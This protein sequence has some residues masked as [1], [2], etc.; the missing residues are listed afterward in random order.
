MILIQ[1]SDHLQ[2]RKWS[3]SRA[4]LLWQKAKRGV[5]KR[6]QKTSS[7]RRFRARALA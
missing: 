7:A 3:L 2:G 5:A 1:K 4:F 6:S